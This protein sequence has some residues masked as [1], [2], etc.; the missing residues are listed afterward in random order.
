MGD[1]TGLEHFIPLTRRDLT[2][3]LCAEPGLTEGDR[4]AFRALGELVAA[5]H[6]VRYNRRLQE[7]KAA[8]PPLDPDADTA[9]LLPLTSADRQ[10]RLNGLYRDFAWVLGRAGFSH[11]SREEIAPA[12]SGASDWGVRMDVD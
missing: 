9:K 8:Y 4:E 2:E 6:H 5:V 7:L 10:A 1:H 3:L 12:L 11:L